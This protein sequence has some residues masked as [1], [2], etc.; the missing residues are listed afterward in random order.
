MLIEAAGVIPRSGATGLIE[1]ASGLGQKAELWAIQNGDFFA[2][3]PKNSHLL[4]SSE[5]TTDRFYG[6]AQIVTDVGARHGQAEVSV[7][8]ATTLVA[9]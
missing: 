9:G 7:R 6:Q 3:D 8:Q 2:D 5:N 4:E 1:F